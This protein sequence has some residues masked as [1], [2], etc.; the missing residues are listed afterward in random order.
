MFKTRRRTAIAITTLATAVSTLALAIPAEAVV[1]ATPIWPTAGRVPIGCNDSVPISGVASAWLYTFTDAGSPT[2]S[3]P[4]ISA[5]A[6]P[7]T[8]VP[9]AGTALTLSAQIDERCSGTQVALLYYARNRVIQNAVV[10]ANTTSD[11]FS[12]RWAISL[13]TLQPDN[14]VGAW[15]APSAFTLRRYDTFTL[16][17]DFKISTTPSSTSASATNITG[18]WALTKS[19]VLRAMTLSNSLSGTKVAKGKTVKATAVLKM[20]T[21]AGYVADASD[22]VVVQTKVGSGKWVSNATLTTTAS[23]VVTYSFVLSTTTSVRFVHAQVL[24]G[25]FTSSIISAV[26]TVTKA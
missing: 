8:I 3:T 10:L 19:Y 24:S 9:P 20:A 11:A 18:P 21:N 5:G 13:G 6:S 22:K 2:I 7:V 26:K 12:S 25:K 23:G 15:T 4:R 16:D 1:P 17:Q 14:A